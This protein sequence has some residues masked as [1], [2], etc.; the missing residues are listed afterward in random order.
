[1][2]YCVRNFCPPR[3]RGFTLVEM[4]VTMAV[5]AVVTAVAVPGF[6]NIIRGVRVNSVY[7]MLADSIQVARSEA[8]RTGQQVNL[9]QSG[10]PD[11]AAN[12]WGCGWIAYVDLN[13]NNQQDVATEPTILEYQVDT[14][15][16]MKKN[17]V[18]NL[19]VISRMGQSAGVVNTTFN[20][21][22]KGYTSFHDCRSMV[23]SV[24]MRL[25][26]ATGSSECPT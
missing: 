14:S 11:C 1:M 4:L 24:A 10:D 17:G 13:R 5:L 22:P 6:T 23:I 20:I 8:I 16:S 3:S 25:R 21:G 7:D 19:F 15:V 12:D 9:E 26:S 2:Q 18:A